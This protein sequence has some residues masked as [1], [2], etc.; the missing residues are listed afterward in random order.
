MSLDVDRIE[1]VVL[2]HDRPA[3][4]AVGPERIVGQVTERIR[5]SEL[6]VAERR[7]GE[8]AERHDRYP[9]GERG[10]AALDLLRPRVVAVVHEAADRVGE[11]VLE[12]GGV[13]HRADV[14]AGRQIVAAERAV[15]EVVVRHAGQLVE[16][17][18]HL[19]LA[20]L[21]LRLLEVASGGHR[22]PSTATSA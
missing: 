17:E 5:R 14:A 4:Q 7:R 16:A 6:D 13:D 3:A 20:E 18:R 19:E 22:R 12:E 9:S 2:R 11:A 21:D 1:E 10:A 15:D 8:A